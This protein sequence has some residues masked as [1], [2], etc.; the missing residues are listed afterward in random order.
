M[1]VLSAIFMLM[2]VYLQ[3]AAAKII[4]TGGVNSD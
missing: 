4:V 2:N 3:S 1:Q